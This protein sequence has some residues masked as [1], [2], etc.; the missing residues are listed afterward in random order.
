MSFLYIS[1]WYLFLG[2]PAVTHTCTY[3]DQSHVETGE[4][5]YVWGSEGGGTCV[6][7]PW[8]RLLK[9]TSS[10]RILPS[11]RQH[12]GQRR[13]VEMP[14]WH[15]SGKMPQD[16]FSGACGSR[17]VLEYQSLPHAS[18]TCSNSKWAVKTEQI[19]TRA[20]EDLDKVNPPVNEHLAA[21]WLTWNLIS[22]CILQLLFSKVCYK[23]SI[24]D[25]VFGSILSCKQHKLI[26]A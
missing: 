1:S 21:K 18:Y 11:C 12:L 4:L 25:I 6:L 3:W 14:A 10:H 23:L 19:P 8:G 13:N 5:R 20:A 24:G 16:I 26:Y 2:G 15:I 9:S 22:S 7:L 17:V